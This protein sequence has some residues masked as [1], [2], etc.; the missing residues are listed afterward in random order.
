LKWCYY[1]ISSMSCALGKYSNLFKPTNKLFLEDK[2][3]VNLPFHNKIVDSIRVI[4]AENR[5][6]GARVCSP[7]DLRLIHYFRTAVCD[8]QQFD[9]SK[10]TLDV[11]RAWLRRYNEI[12]E[13]NCML[14]YLYPGEIKAWVKLLYCDKYVPISA[15]PDV[16]SII[17]C[18]SQNTN[19]KYIGIN[20]KTVD[21]DDL[22]ILK[23]L[24]KVY[25][26]DKDS[27][28]IVW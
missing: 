12:H 8:T 22:L 17:N 5:K 1:S 9:L 21:A 27:Y 14:L 3:F 11:Y 25:P 7:K 23:M 13:L 26:I 10:N 19:I 6:I 24:Y 4:K 15:T 18:I 16:F 28:Q 2:R 20:S